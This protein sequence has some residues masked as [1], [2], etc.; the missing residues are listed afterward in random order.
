[1]RPDLTRALL[2]SRRRFRAEET[3]IFEAFARAYVQF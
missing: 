3:T 1:M 2:E